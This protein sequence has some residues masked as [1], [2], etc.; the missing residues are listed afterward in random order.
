MRRTS[1][2]ARAVAIRAGGALGFAVLIACGS[3]DGA[4]PTATVREGL[5][6]VNG[7]S[8]GAGSGGGS[9][10]GG[11]SGSGSGSGSVG[12][13]P[14]YVPPVF[15]WPTTPSPSAGAD[16]RLPG[17]GSVGPD[18]QYH[19]VIALD[20]PPGRRGM[21]PQLSL[22]YASNAPNGYLG[23]GWS[24][25]GLSAIKP[26]PRTWATNGKAVPVLMDGTD[27]L[28]LD[29][30]Q[31]IDIGATPGTQYQTERDSYA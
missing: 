6:T 29:G 26:C 14:A 22:S 2:T 7:C 18:G 1:K 17:S 23:V 8:S 11:G 25:D 21:A 24:L 13:S 12:S 30:E 10:T 27:A 28:C 16:L 31:L 20:L 4:T 15:E 5:C 19:Y 9:S 3:T